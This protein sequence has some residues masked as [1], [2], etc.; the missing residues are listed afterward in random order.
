VTQI[1]G[2]GEVDQQTVRGA[3]CPPNG[4]R[5]AVRDGSNQGAVL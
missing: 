1:P 4:L 5:Y 3:V 2:Q